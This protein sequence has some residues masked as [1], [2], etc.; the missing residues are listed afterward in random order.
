MTRRGEFEAKL[1]MVAGVY[2]RSLA[3]VSRCTP[4]QCVAG[5]QHFR[6]FFNVRFFYNSTWKEARGTVFPLSTRREC[7][8]PC[9]YNY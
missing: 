2:I 3:R 8:G 9:T 5:Y 4:S 1:D 6:E 7:L